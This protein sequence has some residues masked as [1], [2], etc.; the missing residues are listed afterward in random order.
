MF[1]LRSTED[2]KRVKQSSSHQ[3]DWANG[4]QCT[5]FLGGR[6]K[7]C[8]TKKGT[9]PWWIWRVCHCPT[10]KHV[11]V[12]PRFCERIDPEGNPTVDTFKWSTLCPLAALE[13]MWQLQ[14][15]CQEPRCYRLNLSP[16]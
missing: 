4:W 16:N 1:G 3:W 6:A 12:P 2:V 5:S 15:I 9:R 10:K 8:G 7:L 11:R 14:I 13:L